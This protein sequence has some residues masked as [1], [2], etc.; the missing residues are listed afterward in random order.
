MD[1]EPLSPGG[2]RQATEAS[3]PAGRQ[4]MPDTLHG[5]RTGSPPGYGG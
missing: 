3:H 4:V 5:I 1:H 2:L